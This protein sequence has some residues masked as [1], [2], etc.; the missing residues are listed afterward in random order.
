MKNFLDSEYRKKRNIYFVTNAKYGKNPDIIIF[1]Y[2]ITPYGKI[3]KYWNT[4]RFNGEMQWNEK[5]ITE[6]INKMNFPKL[7][8]GYK[9]SEPYLYSGSIN[10]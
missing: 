4:L 7:P 5:Q 3:S 2:A 10:K 1:W 8:K 6:R 9:W